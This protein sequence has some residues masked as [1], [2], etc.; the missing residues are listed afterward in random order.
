MEL[1]KSDPEKYAKEFEIAKEMVK[2]STAHDVGQP[3]PFDL[4]P[5]FISHRDEE[6]FKEIVD[7]T[8]EIGSKVLDHY[9]E[10]P[11]YRERFGFSKFI[12]DLILVDPGYEID[13]PMTRI[14]IFYKDR[15]YFKL[16][17]INTDGSSGMNADN[18]LAKILLNTEALKDFSEDYHLE[19]YELFDSWVEAS[20]DIYREWSDSKELPN[21]AIVDILESAVAGDFNRYKQAY[22]AAGANCEIVDIRDLEYKDGALY[23]DDYKIDMVYR[24]IVTFELEENKEDCQEFLKAY[25]EGAVCTIGSLRT[26]LIHNKIFFKVLH[27]K[28]THEFLSEDD[29]EFIKNHV[30]ETGIL[31]EDDEKIEYIKAHKDDYIIK[32]MD[33]NI[34]TGVYTGRDM[35]EEEWK[36]RIDED[37]GTGCI[38]QEFIDP[39]YLD[40]VNFDSGELEIEEVSNMMGLFAYKEEFVGT[41]NRFGRVNVLKDP[42]EYI[43]VPGMI[44][45]PRSMED[46]IPRINELAALA[47]KRDLTD[48]EANERDELRQEY[49]RRFRAGFKQH[50]LNVKVVDEE[51]NDITPE[52]LK[53][54][55]NR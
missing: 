29:I 43:V 24:R 39:I 46:I 44:A 21:V 30:P 54:E 14:D 50:L 26:Q 4:Q 1:I 9:I 27:D 40:F 5:I 22:E 51:G 18:E 28:E 55:Q 20:L 36:S 17:E 19:Y 38:Y 8:L 42:G 31:G 23:C 32:P 15:D 16:A 37:K 2:K 6:N 53:K 3:V 12:E 41:Y 49:L 48:D 33:N 10:N 45:I 7:K 25:R 35:S 11:E 52:K 47:K 34:S 13:V